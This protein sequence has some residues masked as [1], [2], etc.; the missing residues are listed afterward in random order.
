[1]EFE[2]DIRYELHDGGNNLVRVRVL[3]AM[4]PAN[5]PAYIL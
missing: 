4:R 2:S 1:M 5:R 3:T